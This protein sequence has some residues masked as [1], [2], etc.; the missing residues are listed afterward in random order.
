M[1]AAQDKIEQREGIVLLEDYYSLLDAL[2]S[3]D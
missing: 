3:E 1:N 2:Y